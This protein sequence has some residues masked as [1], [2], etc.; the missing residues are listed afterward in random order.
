MSINK[1]NTFTDFIAATETLIA[2]GY[3]DSDAVFAQSGSAGG[4]LMGAIANLRPDL[5]AGMV[6]EVPF[7]D[8][9]TTMSDT[10]VPLP[11]PGRVTLPRPLS[12]SD[13]EPNFFIRRVSARPIRTAPAADFFLAAFSF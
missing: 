7:V 10:S 13:F 9:V 1:R 5:Y 3:A 6:A 11:N 4:L 2:Y 8:I 12:L